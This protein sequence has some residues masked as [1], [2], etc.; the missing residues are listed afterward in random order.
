MSPLSLNRLNT[1]SNKKIFLHFRTLWSWA[2]TSSR[3]RSIFCRFSRNMRHSKVRSRGTF[4]ASRARSV[5]SFSCCNRAISASVSAR[6]LSKLF[7]QLLM[8]CILFSSFVLLSCWVH[9][10][11]LSVSF[12]RKRLSCRTR[13]EASR[14][15]PAFVLIIAFEVCQSDTAKRGGIFG[16]V[17]AIVC[18]F[19]F[20]VVA[21]S[22]RT[23]SPG[24][25][26]N[27]WMYTVTIAALHSALF[28]PLATQIG[29]ETWESIYQVLAVVWSGNLE[30]LAVFLERV[31]WNAMVLY[32]KNNGKGKLEF[33]AKMWWH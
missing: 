14:C 21:I 3:T 20:L 30:G 10:V 9:R 1:T 28:V 33:Q 19:F 29:A 24:K 8:S 17:K 25:T 13:C 12:L 7:F 5:R 27:E 15:L 31:D 26:W 16:S 18:S 32:F 6:H 2:S 4:F 22:Q 11:W 23:P